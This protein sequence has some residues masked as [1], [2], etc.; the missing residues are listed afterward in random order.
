LPLRGGAWPPVISNYKGFPTF[1]KQ[2]S[3]VVESRSD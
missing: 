2:K 3:I 1:V